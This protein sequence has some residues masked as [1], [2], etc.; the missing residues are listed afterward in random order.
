[1]KPANLL[2]LFTSLLL[3]F[4]PNLS[5]AGD[6]R[7]SATIET[8]PSPYPGDSLDDAAVWIH[9]ENPDLSVILTTLKASNQKPVKPTGILTYDLSGKQLQFLEDGTPNNIDTRPGFPFPDQ[10]ATLI[11]ASHWYTDKIAF[12]RMNHESRTLN[13]LTEFQSGVGQLRGL[14]MGKAKD[15]YHLIGVGSSGIVEHYQIVTPE[16]VEL[17][18]RWQLSSEAEGCV[19]DDNTNTLFV[20]EENVGVWQFNL[21]TGDQPTA[22]DEVRWFGPLKRGLEGLAL[23]TVNNRQHLVVSVQEKHRFAIY[24]LTTN[25]YLGTFKIDS[26][27]NVDGVSKTDGVHIEPFASTS[28]PKGIMILHDNLNTDNTG[29]TLGQNFKLVPLESL[30]ELIQ[31]LH[32]KNS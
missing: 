28:F 8:D 12:Y 1:M 20:A 18:N 7:L 11:A 25:E 10:P 9:P 32:R 16:N 27:Q 21:F 15:T 2:P 14:C 6:A 17:I 30:I 31:Q 29:A 24:D 23:V 5:L 3:I 13:K 19:I 26:K 22:L 4:V